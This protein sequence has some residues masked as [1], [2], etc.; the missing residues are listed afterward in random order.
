MNNAWTNYKSKNYPRS[1]RWNCRNEQ[2]RDNIL[3]SGV[4]KKLKRRIYNLI[5]NIE[6]EENM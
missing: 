6:I 5:S 4:K 1:F 3:L 2:S